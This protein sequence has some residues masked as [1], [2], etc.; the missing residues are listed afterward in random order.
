MDDAEASDRYSAIECK[1][2]ASMSWRV[3]VA[4]KIWMWIQLKRPLVQIL[5][6]IANIQMRTLKTEVEVGAWRGLVARKGAL[7]HIEQ[8]T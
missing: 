8:P 2:D 6:V 4:N 3:E 1:C 5:V 7:V